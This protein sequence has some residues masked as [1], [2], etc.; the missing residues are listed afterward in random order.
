MTRVFGPYGF[1]W[2]RDVS[3]VDLYRWGH[4]MVVP[5][6]G[7]TFGQPSTSPT[8]QIQRTTGPRTIA[9]QPVGRISF[10]AQDS[11]G[12]PATEDAT[13]AGFRTSQEVAGFL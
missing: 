8:G 7:W 5:Y 4:G 1:D 12:A 10:A 13:Y 2:S 9:R 3:A 6:V 11:E